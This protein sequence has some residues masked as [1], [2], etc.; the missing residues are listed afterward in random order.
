MTRAELL[1]TGEAIFLAHGGLPSLL[2]VAANV[3]S[4]RRIQRS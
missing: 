2:L 1:G 3:L 4:T